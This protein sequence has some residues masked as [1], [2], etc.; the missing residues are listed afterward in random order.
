MQRTILKV[1]DAICER[2]PDVPKS[3]SP[4]KLASARSV[5]LGRAA[6]ALEERGESAEARR[7]WKESYKTSGDIE[8]LMALLGMSAAKRLSVRKLLERA[9]RF[10]RLFT[11]YLYKACTRFLIH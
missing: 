5:A 8:D 10:R 7:Y 9:P 11:W 6:E 1:M 2:F 4:T 3:V